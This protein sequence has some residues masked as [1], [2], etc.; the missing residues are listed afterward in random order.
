MNNYIL[1]DNMLPQQAT[2]KEYYRWK[3]SLPKGMQTGIGFQVLGTKCQDG[4]FAS[5]VYL[6][7]NHAY[8]DVAPVL[9][10]TMIFGDDDEECERYSSHMQAM[11]GHWLLV[12]KHGGRK[13]EEGNDDAT[14]NELRPF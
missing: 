2:L 6:G 7:V 4:K 14:L 3:D 12:E 1:D 8:G 13:K 10:E 9:W 11:I 5:T